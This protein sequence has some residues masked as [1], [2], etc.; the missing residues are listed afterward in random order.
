MIERTERAA[1]PIGLR[2]A[3]AARFRLSAGT[4]TALFAVVVTALFLMTGASTAL[5]GSGMPGAPASLGA[6]HAGAKPLAAPVPAVAAPHGLQTPAIAGPSTAAPSAS[7]RG[8]F[9]TSVGIPN[10]SVGNNTCPQAYYCWNN[11][12][13]PSANLTTG[14]VTGIAYTAYTNSS[15]CAAMRGNASFP[16][17]VTEVGFVRSTNFGDSWSS[18][19]Y[20]GNPACTGVDANYSSAMDPSLTSLANGTFVLAYVEYNYTTQYAYSDLAPPFELDCYELKFDRLVVT[21][22]YDGGLNW[23][24]PM[25][26]N[27]TA[28]SGCPTPGFP[29]LRPSVAAIGGTIYLAWEVEPAPIDLYTGS[30]YAASVEVVAST[31]G[32]ATWSA[33]TTLPSVTGSYFGTSTDV[34]VNPALMVDPAGVLYVAY[35]TNV[36]YAYSCGTKGCTDIPSA[37]IYV[38]TSGDN[39]TTFNVS[40]VSD[41]SYFYNFG[42]YPITYLDP[43]PTIAY[44]AAAHEAYVSWAGTQV[45][46]FCYNEGVQGKYCYANEQVET[47]FF[48]NSS[49]GGATW[50]LA[51]NVLPTTM[52]DPNG[53]FINFA[54]NPAIAV[55]SA[56]NVQLQYIFAN[57]SMC[58]TIVSG[59]YTYSRCG[60][61]VEM[62]QNSS[63]GG[64]TW[65]A[66]VQVGANYSYWDGPYH[67]VYDSEWAGTYAS[68]VTAGTQV[69]LAWVDEQCPGSAT[70][71]FCYYSYGGGHAEV[72]TS[73]LYTGAGISLTFTETGLPGSLNWSIDV[74]GNIR[75]AA[76]GTSLVVSGIPAG[77]FIGY[78]TPWV[79]E[80]YGVAFN[81]TPSIPGPSSF[82]TSSTVTEAFNEVV[83]FNLMSNPYIQSYEFQYQYVNYGMNPYPESMWV[84]VNTTIA[85]SVFPQAYAAFCFN[86]LNVSF[87]A[88]TGTGP[89]SVNSKSLFINVTPSGQVNETAN[90][91]VHSVCDFGYLSGCL[92]FTY[93][94]TFVESGLPNGTDWGVTVT[95]AST[96]QLQGFETSSSSLV[97]GVGAGAVEYYL[98]TVPSSTAGEE[99]IP[100]TTAANPIV[101][102]QTVSIPVTYTLGFASA[103]SFVTQF[104][105]AG[106]PNNTAWSLEV[107]SNSYGVIGNSTN[108][109]L[110]GGAS[111][112]INGS[113]VYLANGTGYY[114]SSVS[115]DP[116]AANATS[117][118]GATPFALTTNGSALVVVQF[119]P[120]FYVTVTASVGGSVGPASQWVYE[121]RTLNLTESAAAGF[122]FVGWTGAGSGSVTSG[123]GAIA[124]RPASPVSEFATFRPNAS[125]TWNL[126]LSS[127]GLPAG[128]AFSVSVGGQTYTGVGS[129]RIPDLPNGSVAVNA[130]LLYLNASETTR[131]VPTDLGSTLPLA[132]GFLSLIANGTLTVSY[133][134]Q[135]LLSVSATAGGTITPDVGA[136]WLNA[137]TV[138]AFSAT[139]SAGHYF[140]G[141]N[142]TGN[143]SFTTAASKT[144][145]ATLN[146]PVTETAEFILRP[147]SA[148]W[149]YWLVV[150]ETGLPAGVAW[151]VS[152]GGYGVSAPGSSLTI[153]GLN[154]TYNLTVAIV[155]VGADTRWVPS[156]NATSLPVTS[157]S[158]FTVT[159]SEEFQVTVIGG[160]G[161]TVTP[162]TQW[163][164][165]NGSVTLTAT[166]NASST[167]FGWNGT[168]AGAY[169]GNQ[170]STAI[171]VLG[172]ITESATFHPKPTNSGSSP[173][174]NAGSPILPIGLLAALLVVGAVVGLLVGRRRGA[175]PPP[176]APYAVEG[177]EGSDAALE[178]E[179]APADATPAWNEGTS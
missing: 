104:Q 128:T 2:E 50:S 34:A 18:P 96:G 109:S 68:I 59:T 134:T 133:Q 178:T 75:Q 167:F 12:D 67:E 148:P 144:G 45:G 7:G 37:S 173:N 147:P 175:S 41:G 43:A 140:G 70:G 27:G 132:N 168:G 48:A 89:G 3:L 159:F 163:V 149:T 108:L 137:T 29:N 123:T 146:A 42:L 110:S 162:L 127:V 160:P 174:S 39:A 11:T 141:W 10:P 135:Y 72:V 165:A 55:D 113:Y 145:S 63:D 64:L 46:Y 57:D 88:W 156:V 94:E 21:F 103:A 58:T 17:A 69:L 93:Y 16:D 74:M 15:P 53:G 169:T 86:C 101:I 78:Y 73:R 151:N 176:P 172:P 31:D 36:S 47:I 121:G 131:F 143:G 19:V 142:G 98:W 105:E 91:V 150:N 161:G 60:T 114:A 38:A 76:A 5:L 177:T 87:L 100:S 118:S 122:H 157:N 119:K 90:F 136:Y 164:A 30:G 9:F 125:A 154:G 115:I 111:L 51:R 179:A 83:L 44:G 171:T 124:I 56:G 82:A 49:D 85:L 117:S 40:D 71:A 106:L 77:G 52:F 14:G 138:V 84:V 166:A 35:T 22:S 1:Q 8:T 65:T 130:S 155:Y 20:L 28:E 95:N 23:T 92:N 26:I 79:N 81:A 153:N 25:A 54:Y 158:T 80:S 24:N 32:G 120:M 129:F 97:V 107:G 62:Y 61:I 4:W 6:P 66:P 116:F 13:N 170:T 152:A 126:T 112:A 102:P 139:P 99:W 33:P